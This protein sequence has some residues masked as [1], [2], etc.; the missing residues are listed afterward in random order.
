VDRAHL[1][2]PYNLQRFVEAQEAVYPRVVEE[3]RAGRK[4]THWMWF[5][6]PQLRGLGASPTS[7]RYAIS[8]LEEAQAYLQHPILGARLL[9]CTALVNSIEGRSIDDIFGYP[10]N[11]KFHSCMTLFAHAAPENPAFQQALQK[12]FAGELDFATLAVL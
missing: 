9:E 8:S 1:E 7:I 12:H 2:D 3:L 10:D 11:L 6:F 5:I 4:R